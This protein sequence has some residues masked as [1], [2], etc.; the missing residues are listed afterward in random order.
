MWGMGEWLGS[1]GAGARGGRVGK[2]GGRRGGEQ[3]EVVRGITAIKTACPEYS[4]ESGTL[5]SL[6]P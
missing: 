3:V 2:T 6:K 5:T 1:G 4:I